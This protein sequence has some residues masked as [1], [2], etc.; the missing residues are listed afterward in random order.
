M[1]GLSVRQISDILNGNTPQQSEDLLWVQ[2]GGVSID[3]RTTA[4]RDLFFA[5]PGKD[6]DGHRFVQAAFD[7]GASAAVVRRDW[8]SAQHSTL[9][10]VLIGVDDPLEALQELARR[11]RR[12][13]DLPVAA[14]VG[15]NG[16]TTTKDMAAR[17]LQ[18]RYRVLKTEGNFNNLIGVP[19]TVLSLSSSHQIAVMEL[20]M[21]AVGELAQLCGLAD[22]SLGVVTN[23]GSAHLQFFDSVEQ[24]ASAKAELLDYL[25][26]SGTALLNGDDPRVMAQASRVRGR[27]VTFG[28]G[29]GCDFQAQDVELGAGHGSRF[30]VRDTTFDLAV[31]GQVN[32]YNALAALSLGV[33]EGVPLQEAAHALRDFSPSPMRMAVLERRGILIINDA[34]NANPGSARAALDALCVL[35]KEAV[36]RRIAI[37]GDMLELGPSAPDLHRELGAYAADC[38]LDH[39]ALLGPLSRSTYQGARDAGMSEQQVRHFSN[40]DSAVRWVRRCCRSGDVVLVKG[41]RAMKMETLVEAIGSL[42]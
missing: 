39:L 33:L 10:G 31:L 38:G 28:L 13:F 14:I 18:E 11:Y 29:Q 17:V 42:Y 19:L 2:P 6:T 12:R 30:T 23:I 25:P 15:T 8:L 7:A 16:K 24:I 21:S 4:K 26:S 41:S 40:H 27:V 3:S 1:Q 35:S 5:L 32:V 37:L 22:P 9:P 36:G 20:G 34:Y